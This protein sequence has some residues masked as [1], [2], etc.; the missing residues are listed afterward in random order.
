MIPAC[1][2]VH[3]ADLCW[4]GRSIA[5]WDRAYDSGSYLSV[6]LQWVC[7]GRNG[8]SEARV[9]FCQ[10]AVA[11]GAGSRRL[12]RQASVGTEI[13]GQKQAGLG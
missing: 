11:C 1:G 13:T 10:D 5:D 3:A 4:P 8:L 2:R 12:R 7:M 9:G 6:G